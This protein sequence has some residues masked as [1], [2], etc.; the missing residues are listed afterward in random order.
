MVAELAPTY[1]VRHQH[2]KKRQPSLVDEAITRHRVAIYCRIS[3][4]RKKDELGVDRQEEACRELAARLKWTVL[5]VFKEDDTTATKKPGKRYSD[6]PKFQ[7]L[8]QM[9]EA[10]MVDGIICW[11]SD[12][13]YREPR[14]L[15]DIID[16]VQAHD[17]EIRQTQAGK[18]DLTTAT[19]QMQA[20][21]H[22]N[23]SKYESDLKSERVVFALAQH[24]RMGRWPGGLRPFGYQNGGVPHPEEAPALQAVAERALAGESLSDLA[25]HLNDLGFTTT[26]GGPWSSSALKLVLTNPRH[27]GWLVHYG[28]R[29][30]RGE[31]EPLW[32][33]ETHEALRAHLTYAQPFGKGN[34]PTWTLLPRGLVVCGRCGGPLVSGAYTKKKTRGTDNRESVRTYVCP[35]LPEYAARGSCG[36]L[37]VTAS[38]VEQAVEEYV[39]NR[40]RDPRLVAKLKERQANDHGPLLR[41]LHRLR[42][43]L[44][45]LEAQLDDA[46]VDEIPR[47]RRSCNAKDEKIKQTEKELGKAT[48][49][50]EDVEIPE[51]GDKWPDDLT[52]RRRLIKLVVA[53]VKV[54]PGKARTFDPERVQI[55]PHE[56]GGAK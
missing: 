25:R 30:G 7:R 41:R 51:P 3:D 44:L 10:G 28:E 33:D 29:V 19:G 47:L 8:M 35:R 45:A 56:K 40:L 4:D 22:G 43:E 17:V 54:M 49:A 12:R 18:I 6:R 21:F 37:T 15:E 13:L 39:Q 52:A 48:Q 2:K 53:E 42:E 9:I 24:R 31:W 20:R 34:R 46:S 36:K 5:Y 14:E 1:P 27:A 38:H 11:I 23:V 55:T 16:T 50:D 26:R 32:D